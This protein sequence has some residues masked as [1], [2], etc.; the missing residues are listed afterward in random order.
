[1]PNDRQ[2][3]RHVTSAPFHLFEWWQMMASRRMDASQALRPRRGGVLFEVVLS[4]A[5]FGGAAVFAL[6]A[7]RNTLA[8]LERMRLQ[9][10]AIDLAKSK[11]A[12]LETGLITLA[13]LRDADGEREK[14][15]FDLHT[16]RTEFT[17][18]T[19]VELTVRQNVAETEHENPM[20]FTLR[21]L[22]VLR[23]AGE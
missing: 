5:L 17:D 10:M 15:T 6:S 13:D 12:E 18:L 9:Q 19:L 21:Q 11:M 22:V 2:R 20:A 1:M 14:W 3:G 7:A 16:S 4:V 23:G 8:S